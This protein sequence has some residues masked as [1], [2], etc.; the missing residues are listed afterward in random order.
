MSEE[1]TE[2]QKAILVLIM[3]EGRRPSAIAKAVCGSQVK[4]DSNEVILALNDLEKRG[5]VERSS[6]KAWMAKSKAQ[7]VL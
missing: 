6:S 4:C 3:R 5:L 2:L 1:I 7:D